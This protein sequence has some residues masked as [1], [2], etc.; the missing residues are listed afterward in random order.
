MGTT[1]TGFVAV[2]FAAL[3]AATT[4]ASCD[5]EETRSVAP[6][7]RLASSQQARNIVERIRPLLQPTVALGFVRHGQW[8]LPRLAD[9]HLR[10][11]SRRAQVSLATEAHR[12]FRVR[13]VQSGVSITARLQGA[14]ATEGTVVD[15]LLIYPEAIA[16][17]GHVIHNAS[18]RGTEDS[19]VFTAKPARNEL[20]YQLRLA[21]SVGGLRLVSNV[22]EVL[23]AK[24]HPRLRVAPPYVVDASGLRRD[25]HTAVLDCAHDTNP[26]P[27]WRRPFV[28]AKSVCT[29]AVRWD[30][31]ALR[32]P[33]LVDP[34]WS[35]TGDM[36]WPRTQHQSLLLPSGDLLVAGGNS[37]Y[38]V[39]EI[40]DA[41]TGSWAATGMMSAGRNDFTLT[42]LD[43]GKVLA[44]GGGDGK[45]IPLE[46][47]DPAQ[48]TW[49]TS[50]A[51]N[52]KHSYHTATKLQDGHV[53]IVGDSNIFTSAEL[54]DPVSD[55]LSPVAGGEGFQYH[56]A[57]LL[58][59]GKV[60][61]A[62]SAPGVATCSLYDPSGGGSFTST[63]SMQD[64]RCLHTAT[65]LADGRVLVVGGQMSSADVGSAEIYDPSTGQWSTTGQLVTPRSLLGA[66]LLGSGMV[67]IAGGF[68]GS[69]GVPLASAELFDP[70]SGQWAST[71]ALATAHNGPTVNRLLSGEVL[72][73]GGTDLFG[74]KLA[75]AEL[76]GLIEGHGACS[77]DG[78][79][80]S[81]F[82][83][84]GVCCDQACL[85]PCHACSAAA[86]GAGVDGSCEP[87]ANGLD[88]DQE[89][90][91]SGSPSCQQNGH[92]DGAGQC[93][94][95][96]TQDGCTPEPCTSAKDCASS[97]CADGICCD[98]AC[99]NQCEACISARK[100]GGVEGIC[101]PVIAGSDPDNDCPPDPGL[102]A[103]CGA[104]GH[105]DGEGSCRTH[106]LAGVSCG[107]PSCSEGSL[108]TLSC[109]GA[110]KCVSSTNSCAPFLCAESACSD[111][112][113]TDL[114]CTSAAW[115]DQGSC[116]DKLADG[117]SCKP[118]K[119]QVCLSKICTNEV[120]CQ[121]PDC[122]PYRCGLDGLC[123]DSCESSGDCVA[124]F[125]C[126]AHSVCVQKYPIVVQGGCTVGPPPRS[127][128][129]AL[130]IAA[131]ALALGLG[132]RRRQLVQLSGFVPILALLSCTPAA[133]QPVVVVTAPTAP[134]I[135]VG[136][137]A[138][139]D[140][141]VPICSKDSKADC[142][143]LCREGNAESCARLGA[144]LL[145]EASDSQAYDRVLKLFRKACAGGSGK[146]CNGIGVMLQRGVG[147]M[148]K[149]L[150]LAQQRYAEACAKGYAGGC[151][152]L[153][154]LYRTGAVGKKD[155]AKAAGY[156]E[157]A[158]A[159]KDGDGCA[160]LGAAHWDGAGVEQD[161]ALAAEFF[162]LACQKDIARGCN[163]LGITQRVANR[164]E[165]AKRSFARACKL[166]S[167]PACQQ[168]EQLAGQAK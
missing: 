35:T 13:D 117:A 91:D 51:P 61:L 66:A 80:I 120:C 116:E 17:G 150:K 107:A 32:Y 18:G 114:D 157:R 138:A 30:D 105:C 145:A 57:T 84:D 38:D 133:E 71:S 163:N 94:S 65:T 95:Y 112:C 121:Q 134:V 152:N 26:A 155:L 127:D 153:G 74:Q 98:S 54:Y 64:G 141:G 143:R 100:G 86:K 3:C 106:T 78:E 21:A 108:T 70:T 125:V 115:C 62:G 69:K 10:S 160:A 156:F 40:Y 43:S 137:Q 168:L 159:G 37:K 129:C 42:L 25:A 142:R 109:D 50:A 5:N 79:C 101:E 149:D 83:V 131:I 88:P 132:R 72:V 76:F 166:G 99:T 24:G 77:V 28:K 87:V 89:C 41:A 53:L 102:P 118:S 9:I 81:Q 67:L 31:N 8:L 52:S 34:V 15:G 7:A 140:A 162:E 111:G 97:F 20:R 136:E 82:C 36:V 45:A 19:V 167:A 92:C 122:A 12:P 151:Y 110:G 11:I 39:A 63:A 49:A 58:A 135:D 164:L 104:D 139:H 33:L 130:L 73:A 119:P 6:V 1:T 103:S 56:T 144:L 14:R 47:Y 96:P 55:T 2:A 23:D 148:G 128:D 90:A 161:R 123:L 113:E 16:G 46:L 158:C 29:I 44:V 4:R 85:Q 93:A 68:S 147:G 124:G 165:E 126:D 154:Q 22:L 146:G 60:L 59:S 48:G 75:S 27:P